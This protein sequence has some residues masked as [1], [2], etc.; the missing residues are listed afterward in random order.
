VLLAVVR[1]EEFAEK[2]KRKLD[3]S[4]TWYLWAL[5]WRTC[6]LKGAE[7]TSEAWWA[8]LMA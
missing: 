1:S 7:N 2:T 8:V 3:G 4:G 5:A 6:C